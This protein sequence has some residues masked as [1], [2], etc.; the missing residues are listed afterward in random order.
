[1]GGAN[2][3]CLYI[4]DRALDKR[5][6]QVPVISDHDDVNAVGFADETSNIFF[7]GGD[8]SIIKVSSHP[9]R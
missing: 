8:D 9:N 7:S 3:G 4:Y 2:D 1:M 6:L 5:T